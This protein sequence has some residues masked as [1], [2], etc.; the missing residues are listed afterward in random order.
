MDSFFSVQCHPS[1]FSEMRMIPQRNSLL[2]LRL[3]RGDKQ[4]YLPT[5]MPHVMKEFL[6]NLLIHFEGHGFFLGLGPESTTK[7]EAFKGSQVKVIIAD[8]LLRAH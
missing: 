1:S 3:L 8:P 5:W 6:L 7:K 2:T 4:D